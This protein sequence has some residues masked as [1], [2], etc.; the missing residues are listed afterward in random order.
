HYS[1]YISAILT[2]FL[3]SFFVAPS[4]W[5][6]SAIRAALMATM[7]LVPMFLGRKTDIFDAFFLSGFIAL[8]FDPLSMVDIGF[9]LSYAAV[10]ALICIHHQSEELRTFFIKRSWLL[11]LTFSSFLGSLAAFLATL[12][13]VAIF[14]SVIAPFSTLANFVLVPLVSLLQIPAILCGLIGALF[15]STVLLKLGAFFALIIE[16]LVE[17]L[18]DLIGYIWYV[19]QL[20]NLS[21]I[22]IALGLFLIM[23]GIIRLQAALIFCALLFFALPIKEYF[24]RD[25]SL[26]V[27]IMAIGQG[28]ATLFSLPSGE[29]LLID[30]GG[31]PYG[32]YDPGLE[33]VLPTLFRQGVKTL[34]V[35]VITH[36]DPDHL[37]GAFALI[38][39][40]PIK[41][42]W[43]SGF[44]PGHPLTERLLKAAE[45]KGIVIKN[46]H[47]LL[48][49]H[50][51]GKT[52]VQVLA[53]QG[54]GPLPYYEALGANDNSLVLRLI[55][56]GHALLWP[57]DIESQGE[58]LLIQSAKDLKATI[59]KAPHHG[60][61]TSS[62]P[63]FIDAVS[64]SLV[65]YSTGPNNR[66]GHPH[67]EVVE[68]F[69]SRKIKSYNTASNGEITISIENGVL[70][71]NTFNQP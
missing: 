54:N 48:G 2:L 7:L 45:N 29:H 19:P 42:I 71:I 66:F 62:S 57:G 35:L 39:N 68:R 58:N 53:P 20:S 16:L 43:H 18:S 25:K 37:L 15:K 40:I 10:F 30:A 56:E 21:I 6:R 32:N 17:V 24:A 28:D 3:L 23:L 22:L 50:H 46:A 5:P 38:D 64:P 11:H 63:S 59:L 8:L 14:F 60:S 52:E 61:K 69:N 27:T 26:R 34:D 4:S 51:F 1:Y 12:P 33:L 70:A 44:K 55:H 65:I 41:E 13:I 47:Q 31:Q 67:A 49:T 9:L 36:P